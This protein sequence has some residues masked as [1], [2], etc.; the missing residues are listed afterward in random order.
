MRRDKKYSLHHI[1]PKSR[2]WATNDLNCEMLRNT[3]HDAIHTLFANEIFPEQVE[4]LT[5]L[6]SK[7]LKPEIVKEIL[8]ILSYR[9]IH[10]PSERYKDGC[11][12]LPRK[13]RWWRDTDTE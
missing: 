3:T 11:L 13:Y 5:N 7:V 8:D 1:L 2:W 4:R 10:D 12:L 6:T 9:D